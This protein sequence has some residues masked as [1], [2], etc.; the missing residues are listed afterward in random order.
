MGPPTLSQPSSL[1]SKTMASRVGILDNTSA[2]IQFGG[3]LIQYS[4]VVG[5][6]VA[7]MQIHKKNMQTRE[8]ILYLCGVYVMWTQR[9][10]ETSAAE[11]YALLDKHISSSYC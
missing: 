2:L 10:L 11:V 9:L 5:V 8:F 6:E 1:H 4:A 7:N 3:A